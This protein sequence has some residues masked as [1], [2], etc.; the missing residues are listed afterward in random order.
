MKRRVSVL[1]THGAGGAGMEENGG[2]WVAEMI[3]RGRW[4]GLGQNDRWVV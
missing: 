4:L 1:F 2:H 3:G